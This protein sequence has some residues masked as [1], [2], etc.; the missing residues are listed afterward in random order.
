VPIPIVICTAA[1]AD[2]REQEGWLT[3]Q[4]IKVVLKPFRIEDLETALTKAL[5][6]I[7]FEEMLERGVRLADDLSAWCTRASPLAR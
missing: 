2:V 3:A 7:G 5:K 6:S 1:N 4:A